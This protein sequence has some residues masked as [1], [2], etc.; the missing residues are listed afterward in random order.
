VT[1]L[2]RLLQLV[3]PALPIGAFAYSQGLEAAVTAGWV[4]D[5]GSARDWIRGLLDA[6]LAALDLPVLARLHAAWGAGD[7]AAVERWNALL[8]AS[9]ATAELAAE[10]RHLGAALARLLDGLGVGGAA[11]FAP[12]TDVAHATMFALAAVRWDVP[13]RA[14]CEGFAFAWAEAQVSAAVR[15]VPLGQSSGQR[16]LLALGDAVPAAAARALA[17]DDDGIGAAAPGLAIASARHETQYSR[18]FRS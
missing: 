4:R 10:D 16:A 14:A 8:L 12:R 9:R 2:P 1:S 13:A 7:G 3:S 6:S 18:L 17:L 5:E 11:P 15:L